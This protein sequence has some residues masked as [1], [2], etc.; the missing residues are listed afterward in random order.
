MHTPTHT[1]AL[2]LDAEKSINVQAPI[3]FLAIASVLAIIIV[4]ILSVEGVA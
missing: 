4:V 2:L 3:I 1:T